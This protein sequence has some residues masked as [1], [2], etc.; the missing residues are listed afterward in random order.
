MS[1][2]DQRPGLVALVAHAREVASEERERFAA[3]A[4][5]I[6]R[7]PRVMV[8]HTC[9]RAEVYARPLASGGEEEPALVLPDLPAGG[10]RLVD[11]EA[12]RHLF[13]VAAGL[14]SVVVGEDQILHQLRECLS[15]RHLAGFDDYVARC[16]TDGRLEPVLERLFQLAL[17]VGRE[18]RSW[19]EGPPRS[20]AD[21]A[22]DRVE[23]VVGRVR[24]RRILVVGAGR[25]SRL[26]ALGIDR[27][28][29]RAIVTN[30]SP[31]RAAALAYD[32]GGEATP[33]GPDVAL[34]PVDGVVVAISGP[35][36]L[37]FANVAALVAS[38]TPI[39]DLSS[40]PALPAATR[41]RLGDR[42]VSVDDLARGPQDQIRE[43][44]RHRLEKCFAEAEAEFAGWLRAR[45]AVPTI[46]ALA[47]RAETRR[48]TELERLFR[49]MPELEDHERELVEQMSRRLV[50]GILHAPLAV[51]ND[52]ASGELEQAA[53]Q[54]FSL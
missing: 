34:P 16:G 36:D 48:S 35:W 25:M 1:V 7:D 22:L 11:D 27:R 21:L 41:T 5:A 43:R 24:G 45:A 28:G 2:P 3:A 4:A 15:E 50:A 44:T 30:R 9:H 18:T 49:R 32:A 51:L 38:G 33:Y 26:A 37:G 17:H 31:E 6:A 46:Q 40:P 52:D 53:R 12:V 29:G 47:D 20:L 23:A 54:L 13:S 19:R 39:V 14:D 8:I 42:Y 10:R